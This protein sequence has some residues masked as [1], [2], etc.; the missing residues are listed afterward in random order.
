[1]KVRF[2]VVFFR[3]LDLL[4]FLLLWHNNLQLSVMKGKPLEID[5]RPYRNG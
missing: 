3:F 5:L 4:L 1:M 2:Q